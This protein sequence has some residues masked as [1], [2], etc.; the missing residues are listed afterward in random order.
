MLCVKYL[1]LTI[2][3][4][5]KWKNHVNNFS[6][7]KMLTF[8]HRNLNVSAT[9]INEQT[10]KSLVR[11]SLEY[12]CYAWYPY[13]KDEMVQHRDTS[14][15][16]NRQ[17]N[18]SCVDDLLQH[19]NWRSLEDRRKDAWLVMIY[20]IANENVAIT[21]LDR[22]KTPLRQSWNLHFLSFIF[23]HMISAATALSFEWH[24]RNI[25]GCCFPHQ[26]L[27]YETSI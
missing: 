4:D 8:L 11:P 21:K 7:N 22:R 24:G 26:I 1:G 18:M 9:S 6:A 5:L 14:F 16:T 10:Y 20:K 17:G 23:P 3:Q 2:G 13:S 12:A 25:Q 15:V 27:N 19:L